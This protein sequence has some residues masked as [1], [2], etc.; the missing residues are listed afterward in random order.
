MSPHRLRRL[1]SCLRAGHILN[2]QEVF[3]CTVRGIA[4][5][6]EMINKGVTFYPGSWVSQAK[7]GL[8][9]SA[10]LPVSSVRQGTDGGEVRL[11]G[12]NTTLSYDAVLKCFSGLPCGHFCSYLA[13][14]RQ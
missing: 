4:G 9:S 3:I 11:G 13:T 8:P 5:V 6:L 2:A 1:L 14:F 10:P 7:G 12:Q